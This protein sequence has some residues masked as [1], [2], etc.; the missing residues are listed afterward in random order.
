MRIFFLIG[1]ASLNKELA[2]IL[3]SLD[4]WAHR[5][6]GYAGIKKIRAQLE[7]ARERYDRLDLS[8]ITVAEPKKIHDNLIDKGNKLIKQIKSGK[9]EHSG[10]ILSYLT[11]L[12]AAYYDLSGQ[13][14]ALSVVLRLFAASSA[15]FLVLSPQFLGSAL[16]LV[17]LVPIFLGIN[18]VKKRRALG[19][20]M[21]MMLFPI[22]LAVSVLWLRFGYNAM[23]NYP[24]V[25][26]Q[27]A[28]VLNKPPEVARFFVIVPP[29]LALILLVTS[30]TMVYYLQ[31]IKDM[32][33]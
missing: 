3:T 19:Y 25:L 9:P 29:V 15:L 8:N 2:Q 28:E 14:S 1:G 11:Y 13:L 12:N 20:R 33:V 5:N 18:A 21:G 26:T 30:S 31:K 4:E 7:R 6:S 22:A 27:T 16:A 24:T 23:V 17:F 32:L 10:Q